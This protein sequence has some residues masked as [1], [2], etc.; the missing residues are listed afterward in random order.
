MLFRSLTS[1]SLI[2]SGFVAA[3]ESS[4]IYN[5]TPTIENTQRAQP[6]TIVSPTAQPKPDFSERQA[7]LKKRLSSKSGYKAI[8]AIRDAKSQSENAQQ[9]THV[10]EADSLVKKLPEVPQTGKISEDT[11]TNTESNAKDDNN[12]NIDPTED[13]NPDTVNYQSPSSVVVTEGSRGCKTILATGTCAKNTQN[14]PETKFPKASPNWLKKSATAKLPTVLPA[15]K[16]AWTPLRANKNQ[17]KNIFYC[18][19]PLTC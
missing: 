18:I 10:S 6:E 11:T 2:S 3:S 15:K 16:S 7:R 19:T 14:Y 4:S 12:N 5:I 8:Q 9:G 13:K 17:Q 1:F